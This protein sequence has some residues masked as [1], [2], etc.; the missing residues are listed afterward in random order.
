[1]VEITTLLIPDEN[2]SDGELT[3]M[4]Q[5]MLRSWPDVPLHFTAF[6]RMKL[7]DKP[8]TPPATLTRARVS[9]SERPELRLYGKCRQRRAART[10]LTGARDRADWKSA[11]RGDLP[12]PAPARLP[13]TNSECSRGPRSLGRRRPGCA[14]DSARGG[15]R[16]RSVFRITARCVMYA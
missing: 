16:C 11:A 13:D 14:A 1:V 10:A 8:R 5:W 12:T 3:L 6:T 7:L 9:R 15:T 4:T 2:D